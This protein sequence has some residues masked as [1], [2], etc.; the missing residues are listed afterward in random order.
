MKSTPGPP[1]LEGHSAC[2]LNDLMLIYGGS[3]EGILQNDLWAYNMG[4]IGFMLLKTCFYV[5]SATLNS[6]MLVEFLCYHIFDLTMYIDSVY[7][8]LKPNSKTD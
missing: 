8:T 3:H 1:S 6:V 5:W 4:K 2:V 7:G